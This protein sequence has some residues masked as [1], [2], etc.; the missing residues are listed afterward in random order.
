MEKSPGAGGSPV[1]LAPEALAAHYRSFRVSER[2][3]LTGHSHQAWPDVALSGMERAWKDAAALVDEKWDRAFE[4]ADRVRGYWGR[5]PGRPGR[6]HRPRS[7][8]LRPGC[9]L[10]LRAASELPAPPRDDR[11]R[12]P[13][14][15]SPPV[16]H[17]G[18]GDRGRSGC[19]RLTPTTWPPRSPQR[20]MTA[21]PRCSY[22]P[23]SSRSGRIVHGLRQVSQRLVHA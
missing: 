7:E 23:C 17:R 9:S 2:I 22:R 21:L 1:P 20:W 12:V 5:A 4:V 16:A 8:H 3:L 6:F 10:S 14:H 13:H 11:R 18:R 19:R 15:P